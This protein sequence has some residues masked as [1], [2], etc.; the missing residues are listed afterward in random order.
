MNKLNLTF[1]A[2]IL[3]SVAACQQT[4]DVEKETAEIKQVLQNSAKAWHSRDMETMT[5][6]WVHDDKS[7]RM[8]AARGGAGM[9]EGWGNLEARYTNAFKN[10]PDPSPNTENFSNYRIK[11][12][13]TMAYV[14]LDNA[15]TNPDGDTLNTR[16][17][18][19]VLEKV[20][21]QWK[22]AVL[23]TVGVASYENVARNR[24]ASS[25]YHRFIPE[26]IDGL[27][28]DD[29]VGHNEHSRFKWNKEDHKNYW[30][31][32]QH[33]ASDTIYYQVANGNWV[34]TL[35]ERNMKWNGKDVNAQVMHFKRFEDGKIAE[36][37]E[38]ADSKQWE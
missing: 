26:D 2:V 30:S 21:G 11:V 9:T 34:A 28:A 36:I 19:Y 32:N 35:F 12:Q 10:N 6:L 20:G 31:T 27:L 29:F 7:V 4:V 14:I 25:A 16:V 1:G 33:A 18:T 17:H 15:I 5:T 22:I 37:F 13:P 24:E 23:S 8:A 3:F 38:F